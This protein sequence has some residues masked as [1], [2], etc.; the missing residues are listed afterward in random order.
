MRATDEMSKLKRTA[1]SSP[2]WGPVLV[3]TVPVTS[4]ATISATMARLRLS[5]RGRTA[6]A[7]G[8]PPV[9]ARCT[10]TAAMARSTAEI[11]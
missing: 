4:T 11:R 6:T 7:V 3:T 8:L 1:F 5:T 2:A 9:H 10:S